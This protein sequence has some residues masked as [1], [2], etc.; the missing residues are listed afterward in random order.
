MKRIL[1]IILLII[2]PSVLSGAITK[3]ELIIKS[4]ES[5]STQKGRDYE[6]QAVSTFWGDAAFMQKCT[7][8]AAPIPDDLDIYVIINSN[9][10]M[11]D[12]YIFPN[13]T[14]G[15]CIK[16][17]V[18]NRKFAVPPQRYVANIKLSFKP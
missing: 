7:P 16:L 10:S 17:N 12:L 3:E 2:S 14:T 18:K 9:G 8:K 15:K 5:L 6:M 13:S 4:K 1:T 11:S